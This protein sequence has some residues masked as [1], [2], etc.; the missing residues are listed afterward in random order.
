[1]VLPSPFAATSCHQGLG[2]ITFI[3]LSRR[4]MYRGQQ[5]GG[6]VHE[7]VLGNGALVTNTPH[8]D[9]IVT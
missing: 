3:A 9:C 4:T 1:M 5:P 6:F 7:R 2:S 8:G